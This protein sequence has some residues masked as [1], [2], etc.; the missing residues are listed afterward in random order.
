MGIY[1]PI[2]QAVSILDYYPPNFLMAIS[3]LH[4]IKEPNYQT[5]IAKWHDHN[6]LIRDTEVLETCALTNISFVSPK[7][8][9]AMSKTRGNARP[10]L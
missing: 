9:D 4:A 5:F 10:R 3:I 7:T 1:L 8:I 6:D 2:E